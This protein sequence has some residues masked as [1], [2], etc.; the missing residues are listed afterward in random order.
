MRLC[1]FRAP[2][3]APLK[4]ACIAC[5]FSMPIGRATQDEGL[6]RAVGRR[7][8]LHFNAFADLAPMRLLRERRRAL[9][10][11]SDFGVHH[12]VAPPVSRSHARF[13]SLAMPRSIIQTG[14]PCRAAASI[15]ST[16]VLQGGGIMRVAGKHFVA[17]RKPI[18]GDHQ[19]DTH[20][21]AIGAV[22]ARV[23]AL[24]VRV[25]CRFAL[26]SRSGDVV[27]QHFVVDREELSKRLDR[28]ASSAALCG[29]N[30]I[31]RPIQPVLVDLRLFNCS[32][33]SAPC[34]DTSPRQC[35]IRSRAHTSEPRLNTAAIFS[36]ATSSLPAAICARRKT[37]R[38][39]N[40]R[41]S[42]SAK[43]T[44]PNCRAV[45]TRTFFSRRP[46]RS[47]RVAVVE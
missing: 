7:E 18:E 37:H 29:S 19:R 12:D 11:S 9:L 39:G 44:S 20:L 21:L 14:L 1:S 28:C 26:R 16:I 17:Q 4:R 31:Q 42:A 46:R 25:G 22:I 47:M 24:R 33:S 5:S 3:D 45:F 32:R 2:L 8:Q 27:E 40:P 34:A 13:S 23:A 43:Y 6:L 38:A 15:V 35:A 30:S 36:H 10:L 41:H